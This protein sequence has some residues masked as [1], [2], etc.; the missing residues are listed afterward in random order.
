MNVLRKPNVQRLLSSR[1][2]HQ[3]RNRA[4]H[5]V[6]VEKHHFTVANDERTRLTGRACEEG[7][8]EVKWR[9]LRGLPKRLT[10][11]CSS[12]AVRSNSTTDFIVFPVCLVC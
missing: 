1:L 8:H 5:F 2:R 4:I 10:Y 9:Q 7:G 6:G 3:T 12:Q 11:L